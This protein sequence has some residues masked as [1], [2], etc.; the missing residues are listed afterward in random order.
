MVNQIIDQKFGSIMVIV[1]HQDD[2]VLMC[3]GIIQNALQNHLE[4]TVVMVTN[5]DYGSTGRETGRARLKETI[6]GM[7]VLGLSAEHII[8]LG[9]ADTGMPREDSF[10]Y[11]LYQEK[12]AG[13]VYQSHC[14]DV[15]YGL[16]EKPEFHFTEYGKHGLYTRENCY[17]DIKKVIERCHPSV[18]FTTSNEDIHG[19][20]CG[21]F[22]FVKDIVGELEKDGYAPKLYSGI[23]HSKAGDGIWPFRT[24]KIEAMSSPPDFE[25]SGNLRWEDRISFAVPTA[26][27]QEDRSKNSKAQALSKHVTALKPDAVEF[28][29]TFLKADEVFWK[30]G[31]TF[32]GTK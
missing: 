18:I 1:P 26:M 4:V 28:L 12:D 14:S 19:D 3:A 6:S 10:L 2:E 16:M 11:R 22:L 29:Y 30:I 17:G 24:D 32:N 5:G 27:L 25:E 21:L 31:E 20:H 15:T 13:K 23:V 8:F 9:Y 7:E